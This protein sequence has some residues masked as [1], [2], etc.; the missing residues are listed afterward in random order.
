MKSLVKDKI[1]KRKQERKV[2]TMAMTKS[3][4]WDYAIGMVKVDGLKPSDEM[5]EMIEKEE[6][7]EMTRAEI[8]KKLNAMYLPSG[9]N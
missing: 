7:G 3:E 2:L 9:A 1:I 5:L 6:R 4:A 8:L